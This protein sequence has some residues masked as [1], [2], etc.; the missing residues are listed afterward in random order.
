[1]KNPFGPRGAARGAGPLAVPCLLIA[2]A[3]PGSAGLHVDV[4]DGRPVVHGVYVNGRGP[5][6]FLVDTGATFNHLDPRIAAKIEPADIFR[7]LLSSPTGFTHVMGMTGLD[8][9][10]APV[11]LHNQTFLLEMAAV[12]PSLPDVEGVLGEEFLS[13]FD[14]SIDLRAGRLE[15]GEPSPRRNGRQIS[16][17]IDHRR[18]VVETS[19]GWLLLD[20]GANKLIR[21]GVLSKRAVGELRTVT[22]TASAGLVYSSLAIGGHV[23]WHGD[24][25]ALSRGA[26]PSIDGLLP[27]GL[28]RSITVCNSAGFVVFE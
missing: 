19:L 6:R 17:R 21:F 8:I 20:S 22:G 2:I 11:A 3:I 25:V 12:H 7:T 24:A 16:Y 27:I 14:Y 1:M 13:H 10:L 18:P 23:Y 15:F 4:R 26:E 28:F 5:F 9:E